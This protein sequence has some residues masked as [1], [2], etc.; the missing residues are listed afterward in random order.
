LDIDIIELQRK[1]EQLQVKGSQDTRPLIQ[2]LLETGLPGFER[3][4]RDRQEDL[5]A[6]P[7][8]LLAVRPPLPLRLLNK[9][10]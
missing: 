10:F 3:D 7:P 6:T 5:Q 2:E 8:L 9:Q 1:L 4:L